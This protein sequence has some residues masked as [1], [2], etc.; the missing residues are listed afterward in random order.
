VLKTGLIYDDVFIGRYYEYLDER[1]K[2]LANITLE[3]L[4]QHT[5][6]LTDE[7]GDPYQHY[8]IFNCLIFDTT[9]NGGTE[10]HHLCE[11]NW[12]KIENGYIAKLKA[13]LD[14]L[15]ADLTLPAYSHDGE[16]AY[17]VAVAAGDG[18]I[19][20]LDKGNIGPPGQTQIEPCDLYTVTDGHGVFNH[21]K[22]STLSAQLSHLF[23]QG[24]NAIELLK[25]DQESVD[26]LKAMISNK[27]GNGVAAQFVQPIDD[28]KYHVVFGIV[29][30]KDKHLK[31]DNLPL[32]SRI[33]LMRNMKALQT[34]S[35][36][37][38]FGF[39]EDASQKN[40]GK[41]K[42]RK[43]KGQDKPSQS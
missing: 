29:T 41:Q 3:D 32:F 30:H 42:K 25:L 20:C 12:Y 36:R 39:I 19:L 31:S 14:P 27:V 2:P 15:C 37:A 24:T 28:K 11:G 7:D 13:Y 10:T 33:S 23:N 4:K 8:P 17:N 34:M 35:V 40:Q 22:I 18:A 9:L 26:R 1:G 6:R 5:L 21:V 43:K 16:G 38:N